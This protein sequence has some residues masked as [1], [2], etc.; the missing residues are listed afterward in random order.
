MAV[1][2]PL[3]RGKTAHSWPWTHRYYS[4]IRGWTRKVPPRRPDTLRPNPPL[5][6]SYWNFPNRQTPIPVAVCS[7]RVPVRVAG[8]STA[9]FAPQSA[10][11]GRPAFCDGAKCVRPNSVASIFPTGSFSVVVVSFSVVAVDH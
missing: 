2:A 9:V 5:A 7:R 11:L 1:P 10:G 6:G 8:A 4:M 3:A